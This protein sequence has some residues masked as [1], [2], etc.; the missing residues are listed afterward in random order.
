MAQGSID[1]Y[2]TDIGQRDADIGKVHVTSGIELEVTIC[3]F[4]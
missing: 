3:D 2:G 1:L 4:K